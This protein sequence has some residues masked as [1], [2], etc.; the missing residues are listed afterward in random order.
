MIV[1][2]DR[3]KGP[4]Y[5]ERVVRLQVKDEIRESGDPIGLMALTQ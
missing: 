4:F 1:F 3:E 2:V 5:L